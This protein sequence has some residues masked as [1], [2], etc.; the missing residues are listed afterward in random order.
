MIQTSELP[1]VICDYCMHPAQLVS[2]EEIHG[3][4]FKDKHFWLCVSCDAW[5]GVHPNSN[6]KPL[7]RL[8][9]KD[10][11]GARKEANELFDKVVRKKMHQHQIPFDYARFKVYRWLRQKLVIPIDQCRIGKFDLELCR[12]CV[13]ACREKL[14]TKEKDDD[15]Q[16]KESA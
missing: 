11:R 16:E 1:E 4:F 9:D 6:F 13:F 8:A 14:S 10:L 5:T 12:Q 7:G 15:S 3:D 2:G